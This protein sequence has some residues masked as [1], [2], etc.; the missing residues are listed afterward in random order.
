MKAFIFSKYGLPES[1]L[2]LK[3]VANPNPAED[4]VLVKIKAAAVNDYDWSMVRG[5]PFLYR[6]MFGLWKPKSQIPGMELSGIIEAV[7]SEVSKLKVGDSVYGDISDDKFGAFAEYIAVKAK[8]LILMPEK[9]SFE[10]AASIAHA[11]MLACQGL[12]EVGKIKSHQSI[13]V[14]G[15]GG[16]V[17]AFAAQLASLY[18]A[19]ITG[20]DTSKKFD[21]MRS[22]GYDRVIDYKSEDF[23]NL[24][25]K[26]GQTYDLILDAKTNR[27]VFSYLKVLKPNGKYVTVGGT[28]PKLISILVFKWLIS[29]FTSK[30]LHIVSLK[31]NKV[32]SFIN[33]L[34]EEGKIKTIIDGPHKFRELPKLIQYFGD[35]KHKGKIVISI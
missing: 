27:S 17:G 28:L 1:V 32:L 34:Y 6:L 19:N 33:G 30:S 3:E 8:S 26:K 20:V 4:E 9:M 11:S 15:A 12:I 35:G 21:Q 13:L 7:G 23:T 25:E 2:E 24:K 29:K 18:N 16:G 5:K 31:V 14:N 22:H 10:E